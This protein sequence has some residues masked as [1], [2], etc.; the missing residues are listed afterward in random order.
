MKITPDEYD[1]LKELA[2]EFDYPPLDP[3]KHVTARMLADEIGITPR[4]AADR[5]DRLVMQG[6]LKREYV[7]M[8][9]GHRAYGYYR[10]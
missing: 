3:D 10:D 6:R 1:L 7:R 8:P 2:T 9:N 5:L 4:G